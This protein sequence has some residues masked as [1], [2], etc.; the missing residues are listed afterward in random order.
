MDATARVAWIHARRKMD[1]YGTCSRVADVYARR[2]G[3]AR[4]AISDKLG[5][6]EAAVWQ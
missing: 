2:A 1:S 3:G 4:G 6:R 5:V